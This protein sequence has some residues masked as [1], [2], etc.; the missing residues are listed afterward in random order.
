MQKT[1]RKMIILWLAAIA[2]ARYVYD[3]SLASV[4]VDSRFDAAVVASISNTRHHT[5]TSSPIYVITHEENWKRAETALAY[6][7]N[8]KISNYSYTST[9]VDD[10]NRLLLSKAFWRMFSEDYI[11]I[12]QRDSRFCSYS[13]QRIDRFVGHFD[14]IGAPWVA[15][16]EEGIQVGNGGFSLRSKNSMIACAESDFIKPGYN[17]DGA[18]TVCLLRLNMRLPSLET[19]SE[20]AVE[21]VR[22]SRK[23]PLAI[24]KSWVYNESD[25]DLSRYCPESVRV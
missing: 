3:H 16:L 9:E 11:L 19:A 1:R 22:F 21:Q 18:M 2:N 13:H 20:F 10:Y 4:I 25:D 23:T 12:F 7:P 8:V 17:E 6:M 5:P 15:P 14:F 24:H